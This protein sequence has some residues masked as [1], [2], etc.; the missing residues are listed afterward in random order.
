M[1][2]LSD[3]MGV[4]RHDSDIRCVRHFVRLL[5]GSPFSRR[6]VEPHVCVCREAAQDPMAG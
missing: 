6:D 3:R 4:Q 5:H 1:A 2:R